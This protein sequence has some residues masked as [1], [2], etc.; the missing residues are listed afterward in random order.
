MR[1]FVVV[2]D[3]HLFQSD[4]LLQSE[5]I[6]EGGMAYNRLT[7]VGRNEIMDTLAELRKNPGAIRNMDSMGWE[8]SIPFEDY[9]RIIAINPDLQASCAA[10]RRAAW[11][12][13]M[14][15]AESAPYRVRPRVN[16][17]C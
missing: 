7:Q 8:L 14:G 15:T 2:S 11:L 10:T 6:V 4:G 13:F 5:T 16:Y 12:K 9:Y 3:M 1:A 17:S